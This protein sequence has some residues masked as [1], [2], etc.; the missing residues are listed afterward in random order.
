MDFEALVGRAA[1]YSADVILI[2]QKISDDNDLKLLYANDAFRN[3]VNCTFSEAQPCDCHLNLGESDLTNQ[4]LLCLIEGQ[5]VTN[6]FRVSVTELPESETA[7]PGCLL[8]NGRPSGTSLSEGRE[9]LY[10]MIARQ[11]IERPTDEAVQAAVR[12]SGLYFNADL[13]YAARMKISSSQME[14][15]Y[16]WQKKDNQTQS[17]REE[18]P[19]TRHTVCSW[20]K[21]RLLQDE[22]VI[23]NQI[24][25]LP[26]D[27]FEMAQNMAQQG[28]RAALLAPVLMVHDSLWFISIHCTNKSRFWNPEDIDTFKVVG[29]LLG[30]AFTQTE[31]SWSLQETQRRFSDVGANLPGLIY[32]MQRDPKGKISFG[33]ISQGVRE[34]TGWG[35]ATMVSSPELFEQLIVH[36]DRGRFR[37][38]M[39]HA[40]QSLNVWSIDVRIKHRDEKTIKW[41]RASG[42][43]HKS[44]NGDTIWNG[45]LLD[46]TDRRNAENELRVSEERLRRILGTSPIAIGISDTRSFK[47]LFANKM[48]AQM[49]QIPTKQ[50]IGFDS[51]QL[52]VDQNEH[53]SHWQR[54]RQLQTL[55]NVETECRKTD[56]SP[57]WAQ[58]T[59]RMI[60]Y[61]GQ[62]AIL[63]WAFDI[64]DHRNAK[65]TLAH[66]AHHDSL[67]GLANRRLFDEH[68]KKAIALAARSG[69]P[70]VLFY[71]DLDGFKGVNDQ[72]GH[73]FGD[74]V[75]DQVGHRLRDVLRDTDTGA[76]LGG[77]EFAVI[78]QGIDDKM[79]IEAVVHKLQTAICKPYIK[80]EKTAQIGLSIGIVQ[81]YGQEENLQHLVTLADE[82]MY[83][84]KQAGKGTYRLIENPENT[85][86]KAIL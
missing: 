23:V 40:A 52:Y 17:H 1:K 24:D 68:F 39:E 11:F 55:H 30:N 35:P 8:L 80:G 32:Q 64:T 34:L 47:L 62:E 18:E 66:L 38:T 83:Q 58:I 29:D 45:L 41:V 71:F 51:R 70:G 46:I 44:V 65:E 21:K 2:V 81:F 43:A 49:Y 74:W 77:D 20:V 9:R 19:Q 53:K 60:E 4:A 76:R 36:Q 59:T 22:A 37:E 57:F 7:L 14:M 75:L 13:C 63:W 26:E 3:D 48:L 78:A 50:I 25:D 6:S 27:A 56:G 28:T 82:A 73:G 72:Y 42:R 67:T 31:T 16:S 69:R 10:S 86:M 79:A 85:I 54:T 15:R 12:A 33:Y 5:R 61:G 84:A